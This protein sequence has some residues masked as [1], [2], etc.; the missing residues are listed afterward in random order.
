VLAL[1][2]SLRNSCRDLNNYQIA[3]MFTI[4]KNLRG[5]PIASDARFIRLLEYTCSQFS[6]AT[7]RELA[8]VLHCCG[9]LDA[10]LSAEWRADFWKSTEAVMSS[11][12][13]QGFSNMLWACGKLGL[14]PP[15]SWMARYWISS[16]ATLSGFTAQSFS[17]TL[18]A[19]GELV[20]KPPQRWLDRFWTES[21]ARLSIFNAQDFSNTLRAC[22][23]LGLMPPQ[24]WLD[25]YWPESQ[26]KLSSFKA[27]NLSNTLYACALLCMVPPEHWMGCFCD[28][29]SGKLPLF[30]RQNL[31]NSLMALAILEQFSCPIFKPM[32]S[33]LQRGLDAAKGGSDSNRRLDLNQM[34][35]IYRAAECARP[36][37]LSYEVPSLREEAKRF[38]ANR[39]RS[40]VS[41]RLEKQVHSFL[42]EFLG[43][44]GISFDRSVWCDKCEHRIDFSFCHGDRRVAIGVDGPTHFI[45]TADGKYDLNG[46]TRLRNRL[47]EGAGWH[48][49]SARAP[50]KNSG[51]EMQQ[52]MDDLR[53][54][55]E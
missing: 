3:T 41:S 11:F 50:E 49:V 15:R 48:V 28:S 30:T 38:R 7:G 55:F 47:L 44:H 19:C 34:S 12:T 43:G 20:L 54:I 22:G 4:L 21:Q 17:N 46:Q 42:I 6:G 24:H 51:V 13:D 14:K 31:A 18:H 27:Q 37:M 32:W 2:E 5:G 26:A 52:L 35:S 45:Q 10:T 33:A 9:H 8:T 36:G 23:K 39:S 1:F 53:A 40:D 25:C 29:S 16:E